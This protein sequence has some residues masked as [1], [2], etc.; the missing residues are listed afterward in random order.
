MLS[1][2]YFV[3]TARSTEGQADRWAHFVLAPPYAAATLGL[4]PAIVVLEEGRFWLWAPLVVAW[5]GDIG[6]YFAGRAF[7]KH[8]CGDRSGGSLAPST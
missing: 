5:C 2:A 6:G 1:S 7:G 4:L 3:T 8:T